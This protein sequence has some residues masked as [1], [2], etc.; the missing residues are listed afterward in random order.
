MDPGGPVHCGLVV[1][2]AGKFGSGKDTAAM[3]LQAAMPE[4]KWKCISFAY[5]VK[6]T[7]ATL[8]STSL[9]VNM[10][11][12]GKQM[13]PRGFSDTLGTLQQKVGMAMREH[14]DRNVW[15]QAAFAHVQ[16][17]DNV[18]VTDFA[19]PMSCWRFNRSGTAL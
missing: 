19:S 16:P 1:G 5:L 18:L 3:L 7:V 9:D 13:V 11:D 6:A 15:V 12:V 14:I 4:M 8:T 2:L 17:G 10:D